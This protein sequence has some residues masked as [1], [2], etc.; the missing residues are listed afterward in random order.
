MGLLEML[1]WCEDLHMQPVLAVFAGYA[2]GG[3]HVPAGPALAPFVQDALD[4]VEYVAGG[5]DTP[6][7]ARRAADGHPAPFPLTYVEIG[8]EDTF[9]KSGSYDGRY[10]Q[11]YDA[12]KAKHPRLQII[13]TT[14]VKGHRM[15]VLD[16]HY[17]RSAAEMARDSGHYDGYDRRGPKIFVGEWASTEGSPTPTMQAA[18]GD[19]AWLTGL[20]RNADLVV[21]EAYAPLLVN[22]NPGARQWG[23]NLIGY[24]ALGSFGSPSYHVQAMFAASTGDVSLPVRVTPAA[25][26]PPSAF[27]PRGKIGVAT[28]ATQA[29]FKDIRVTGGGRTLYAKDFARG[30]ADWALGQGQ[31]QAVGGVLR[32]TGDAE[33]CQATAGDPAWGDYTYTL[34]ARKLG[35]KE[36]FLIPF[37]VA[38]DDDKVWWNVGGWGDTRTALQRFSPGG[39]A[40]EFGSVP[41]TVETGRWYDVRVELAGRRIRCFLD[42]KLIT[43][44]DDELPPP[45]APLYAAASRDTRTGALFLQVVNTS[46]LPQPLTVDLRGAPE[47]A[48][49]AAMTVLAGDPAAVNTPDAP[50]RVAP[51]TSTLPGVGPTF[52]HEFPA[53]S[54]TTLR[55]KARQ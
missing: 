3:E 36:G 1:E 39:G 16:D 19:A 46:P 4:E 48:P 12:L 5:P 18:L 15:D 44:A 38:G 8:N 42:G 24:D 25:A 43:E 11:F 23:T 54:V 10:A 26:P 49:T 9:D 29:E 32:Q 22:V 17:Y 41:M 20:E 33:N 40:Q 27:L 45:P 31:W 53:H 6:W 35:G 52:R 55:L 37:H 30:A 14:P 47:L 51:M 7:G 2:L 50:D 13:A 21:M 28:W 34:K